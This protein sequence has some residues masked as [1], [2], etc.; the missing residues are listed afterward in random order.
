MKLNAVE[1]SVRFK[2]RIIYIINTRLVSSIVKITIFQKANDRF[3]VLKFLS[4]ELLFK[5][6]W[7]EIVT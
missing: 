6:S 5:K 2:N 3:F 7:Q 1:H 4:H